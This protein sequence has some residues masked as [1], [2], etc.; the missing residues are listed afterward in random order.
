MH[1]SSRSGVDISGGNEREKKEKKCA[2]TEGEGD[3]GGGDGDSCS[4]TLV[5]NCCILHSLRLFSCPVYWDCFFVVVV[6]VVGGGGS[7]L[8]NFV[9]RGGVR[10]IIATGR[11]AAGDFARAVERIEAESERTTW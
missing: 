10:S 1:E 3:E 9:C 8:F 5:L 7:F 6:V 11:S 2:R 4:V